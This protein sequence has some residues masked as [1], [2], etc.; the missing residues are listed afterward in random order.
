[1]DNCRHGHIYSIYTLLQLFLNDWFF[2][3]FCFIL[4]YF[5]YSGQSCTVGE[6]ILFVLFLALLIVHI[7]Y[8]GVKHIFKEKK[9]IAGV[10]S[11]ARAFGVYSQL[12]LMFMICTVSRVN[13]W[14]DCFGVSFE[15]LIA[16]HRFFGYCTLICVYIHV[17]LF[18]VWFESDCKDASLKQCT[19]SKAKPFGT[20]PPEYHLDNFS[21]NMMYYLGIFVF[22]IGYACSYSYIRRNYFELFYYTHLIVSFIFITAA[23][24]HAAQSWRYI[25]PSLVLYV[26]DR[27]LRFYFGCQTAKLVFF[28]PIDKETT[29]ISFALDNKDNSLVSLFCFVFL[30]VCV[31]VY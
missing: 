27:C 13:L 1:M 20:N 29:L 11:L 19:W 28:E 7:Y 31:C 10:H 16:I 18:L 30:H 6:L 2:C 22:P 3:L 9:E 21:Y 15:R 14:N 17:A 24:W 12:F 26:F 25:I 8:W 5:I 23:L 4:F